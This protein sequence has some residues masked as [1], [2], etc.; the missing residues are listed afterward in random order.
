MSAD[1]SSKEV[2]DQASLLAEWLLKKEQWRSYG[3]SAEIAQCSH[4]D[5]IQRVKAVIN[6]MNVAVYSESPSRACGC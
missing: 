5:R 4:P 3:G 2:L 6:V 1:V